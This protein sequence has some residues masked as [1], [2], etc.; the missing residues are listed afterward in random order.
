MI[1]TRIPGTYLDLENPADREKL[2]DPLGCFSGRGGSLTI[3]DEIQR[4][5]GSLLNAAGFAR[6]LGVDGKSGEL[7]LI[8]DLPGGH[9]WAI[10]IKRGMVP[11]PG[12]GF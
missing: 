10:E 1:T 8:L 11:S 3:I 4:V 6:S 9:R 12:K 5:P 2:S 7:D